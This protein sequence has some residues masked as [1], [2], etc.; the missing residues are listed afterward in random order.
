MYDVP[1][2]AEPVELDLA[3][4]ELTTLTQFLEFHRSVLAHRTWGLS[5]TE[6]ATPLAPSDLTLGGLLKHMAYVEDI[7]FHERFLGN[8][9]VEPWASV[10]WDT[11]PDWEMHS[12]AGDT[13]KQLFDQYGESCAR[14]RAVTASASLDQLSVDSRGDGSHWSMR[15]ILVHM[16]EEYA[17]HCGHAD[18][19]RESIDGEVG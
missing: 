10:D 19:I 11:D 2:P 14:S 17:R 13:P 8:E 6:L 7:W 5:Q 1:R 4:D 16:I 18:F 3:G 15:W 9:P 12:A